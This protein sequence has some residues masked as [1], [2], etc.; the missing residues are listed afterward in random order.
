MVGIGVLGNLIS[1]VHSSPTIQLR[2]V[3]Y[4]GGSCFRTSELMYLTNGYLVVKEH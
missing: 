4:C 1:T 3:P 2:G